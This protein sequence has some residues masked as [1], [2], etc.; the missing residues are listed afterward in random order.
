[1]Y[2]AVTV[3]VTAL[4]MM[5]VEL[6]RPGRS[7]PRVANWYARALLFN[8]FQALSLFTVGRL[9]DDWFQA[10]RPW[11]FDA[12]GAVGAAVFGYVIHS[13]VYY[14]WHRWRH[15]VDFLWRYLHQLHHSPQRIEIV[16]SFY[17]HPLEIAFNGVL[18]SAVLYGVLGL[19]AEAATGAFL[20][21]GLAELVY[22]WNVKTPHWLG[23]FIQ[24][25]EIH[26]V[27][28]EEGLHHFNYGD[29]PVFDWMFGTLRNPRAWEK[30]CGL[31]PMNEHR[32]VEMLAGVNVTARPVSVEPQP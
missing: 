25:P 27:H 16:T 28:H 21:S 13:F 2:V 12:F 29:L 19:S 7:F 17:K 24:R 30:T 14:W 10:H 9:A 11:N 26:C 6:L 18:S 3:L 20:L 31:G 4:L 15:E 5:V 32:V 22:H 1:M 8:G 23:Y